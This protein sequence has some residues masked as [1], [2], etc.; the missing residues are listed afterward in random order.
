MPGR[1]LLQGGAGAGEGW[2]NTEHAYYL[3]L[4]FAW[5]FEFSSDVQIIQM[6]GGPGAIQRCLRG[7]LYIQGLSYE[8]RL[9]AVQLH[10]VTLP[11]QPAYSYTRYAC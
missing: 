10:H 4:S 8:M 11:D 2:P 1:E 6:W 5:K 9:K 3:S 7:W